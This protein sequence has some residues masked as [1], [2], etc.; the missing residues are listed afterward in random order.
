MVSTWIWSD[1]DWVELEGTSGSPSTR[2]LVLGV[3]AG[4]SSSISSFDSFGLLKFVM[5]N[6]MGRHYCTCS[7]ESNIAT[8]AARHSCV[9]KE[10]WMS[11]PVHRPWVDSVT[12]RSMTVPMSNYSP[13]VM[14]A[15]QEYRLVL[16]HCDEVQRRFK[17]NTEKIIP[18][19]RHGRERCHRKCGELARRRMAPPHAL[20]LCKRLHQGLEFYIR[21]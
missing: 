13:L 1:R 6:G 15:V 7:S 21:K 20:A 12:P 14:D 19:L 2:L 5:G 17:L 16:G 8:S 10:G 11:A 9:I 4:T 18:N 3:T